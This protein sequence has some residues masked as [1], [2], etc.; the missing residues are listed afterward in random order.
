MDENGKELKKEL[1]RYV[2]VIYYPIPICAFPNFPYIYT[3]WDLGHL[4]TY[5]FPEVSMNGVF[6]A[7]KKHHDFLPQ[8]A[9]MV[10]AE[11]ES[12][13]KDITKYLGIN[14]ERIKVVP[15]FPSEI[16]NGEIAPSIPKKLYPDLTFIH[17]PSQ[18]WA[19]KNH[20]NLLVAFTKV[21]ARFPSVKLV[22]TGSDKG[23][24][25][26]I[27]RVIMQYGLE[28]QVIDL[29]FVSNEELKW[30]YMNSKGLVMPTF[31]GPT[32]MPLLE[33][34]ALN[35]PIA[36]SRLD[37]HVEELGDYGY[38]FDPKNPEE[39]ANAICSMI[40]DKTNNATRVYKNNFNIDN[41]LM[42]IDAAFSE[43]KN[44]RFCWGT[45]DEIY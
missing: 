21:I 35:C 45:N 33:A 3:L 37:G 34:A 16:V 13:R 42:A 10:F 32:N 24:K 9:L 22:L 7:R 36:C 28:N 14:E 8:K 43:L 38:Y 5:A 18:Y 26:Y 44:I 25:E 19:H 39:M 31:L 6:E 30:L 12:G 17:Y 15:L 29:G 41:A 2:D 20:Y 4:S 40:E 23:N 27:K 1:S 11:S